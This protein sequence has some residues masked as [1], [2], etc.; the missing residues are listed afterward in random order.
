MPTPGNGTNV[1]GD[2]PQEVLFF[3]TDGVE[4]EMVSGSRQQSVMS[5][6][7]CTTIKNRVSRI[8]VLY[9]NLCALEPG[10]RNRRN[11]LVRDIT[12]QPFQSQIGSTLESCASPGLYQEV[13]TDQD[14]STALATLFIN[15]VETAHL[16]N[17]LLRTSRR[18]SPRISRA[19]GE[20]SGS[21]L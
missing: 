1:K 5:T 17:E 2:S 9:H 21:P 20:T 11:F 12:S 19:L 18:A 14:I 8:A 7:E 6:S 3:V 4:D 13:D 16:T 10:D 15:A